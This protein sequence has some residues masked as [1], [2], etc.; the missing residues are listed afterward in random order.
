MTARSCLSCRFACQTRWFE[1]RQQQIRVPCLFFFSSF[2]G[3]EPSRNGR[4]AASSKVVYSRYWHHT[5]QNQN[6]LDYLLEDMATL[7]LFAFGYISPRAWSARP[8]NEIVFRISKGGTP[9]HLTFLF[10]FMYSFSSY[11][12]SSRYAKWL[13]LPLPFCCFLLRPLKR[14][15]KQ[16]S[17]FKPKP[18]EVLRTAFTPSLPENMLEICSLLFSHPLFSFVCACP[19]VKI[20]WGQNTKTTLKH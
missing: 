11:E 19:R 9:S 13:V 17:L 18:S 5:C 15:L 10:L 12:V 2:A 8:P 4:G 7:V 20:P 16:F 3:I 6:S 1:Q 14:C